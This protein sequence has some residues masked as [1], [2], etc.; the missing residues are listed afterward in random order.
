M[1]E[2][3]NV[4]SGSK[5]TNL[6]DNLS[7]GYTGT[8]ANHRVEA[9]DS[10]G[11][12]M[13]PRPTV[14]LEA[15]NRLETKITY[16]T[17]NPRVTVNGQTVQYTGTLGHGSVTS[18]YNLTGLVAGQVNNI[19]HYIGGSEK[20]D[21]EIEYTVIAPAVIK[22]NNASDILYST[23]TLNGEVVVTNGESPTR[24][25]EFGLTPAYG[26]VID[27]GIGG[28]GVFSNNLTGLEM[29]TI[30][31]Y[32]AYGINAEGTGYGAQMTFATLYPYL[33]AP[34]R[35]SPDDG[36]KTTERKPWFEITLTAN[37]D[38]PSTNYH[39]RVRISKYVNMTDPILCDSSVLPSDW[40]LW[41]GTQWVAFPVNGVPPGSKVRAKPND[42]LGYETYYWDASSYDGGRYGANTTS[43]S[44]RIMLTVNNLYTLVINDVNISHMM[45]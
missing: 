16:H 5:V 15:S 6:L 36:F 3:L 40:E 13:N 7:S 10:S 19:Y 34:T 30:Y 29:G 33:A 20:V 17:V 42:Y 2:F 39:A 21:C 22:T 45:L 32:R 9:C 1:M 14:F 25:F 31:Y 44:I 43:R 11:F 23:A 37:A 28:V 24:Y 35:N 8:V 4:A 38:N 12:P 18:W 27:K 41:D 26:T